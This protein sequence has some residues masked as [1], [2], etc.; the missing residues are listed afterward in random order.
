MIFSMTSLIAVLNFTS[1]PM[2]GWLAAAALPWLIHRWQQ[3]HFQVTS[4]AAV[5]LLQ[6]AMR[7]RGR[8][9]QMQQWLLLAVRTAVL[10]LTA[11]AASEPRLQ[12]WAEGP[13]GRVQTH[14]IL[15]LDQS[16]S[17]G[18]VQA[19]KTRWQSALH[20]ARLWIKSCDGDTFTLLASGEQTEN[21]LGR[22]TADTSIALAALED[23]QL[24][25]TSGNL[26]AVLH[27]IDVAIDRAEEEMPQVLTHHVVFCTDLGPSTWSADE[28]Q[29]ELLEGLAKRASLTI[30]NISDG[31]SNNLAVADVQVSPPITLIQ[32]EATITA[33]VSCFGDSPTEN[34]TVDLL[35]EG[36]RVAQ[37]QIAL[38][39]G[40]ETT[41]RFSHRFVDEGP[42]TV[43]VTLANHEDCLQSDD[44]RW[45]IV[46]VRPQ[47]Q[48][49]CFADQPRAAD[50]LVRA[51]VP[52]AGMGEQEEPIKVEV[53]P[54]S[55]LGEIDLSSYAAIMLGSVAKLSLRE[56]AALAEYV[57]Q[58]GGLAIFLGESNFGPLP[59]LL[60]VQV[61]NLQ[62]LGEYH[63]D[64]Q[65]Y[66]HVIVSPFRGQARSGLL[67]VAISQYRRLQLL[68][69]H[70]TAEVVLKFDT[71]D[72]ALVVDDFGLGRVSVSA[73]PGALAARTSNS[74]PWSSFAMSP[75][76]LPVIRELVAYL[77]GDRWFHQRNI[78]V[79]EPAAF[80]WNSNAKPASVRLP[81]GAQQTLPLSG[82]EDRGQRVFRETNQSGIYQ[83]A[84]NEKEL[85][86]FAVNLDG[87][88]SNLA[89][90]N[91]A[92]LPA[93]LTVNPVREGLA[94]SAMSDS[95][96]LA[97]TLL[98]CA[99]GLLLLEVSLA[100][101]LGRRWE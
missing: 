88:D 37:Q 89:P 73:L 8:R 59:E 44:E 5:E 81:D 11:L 55:R 82:A 31:R 25:Q 86:R 52:I 40:T 100:Y 39:A 13:G 60:P 64:P 78:S 6:K 65:E 79:G 61:G 35:V 33:T 95:F 19:G 51:L 75:S 23:L 34:T 77:V 83:F 96:P 72:P 71:G 92:T 54:A 28:R 62:P 1:F 98:A 69:E 46:N 63:F 18:C 84:S 56:S 85:A 10:I 101:M 3:R 30:V 97:R 32:R 49:A 53:F 7:H 91:E 99:L 21:L 4:W 45:L 94:L 48:V 9:V 66:G 93:E 24:S 20:H 57:R 47:L 68:R 36:R 76:F 15:V 50:D 12:Q 17:M 80:V 43:Q 29:R 27:A 14:R 74:T 41:L 38:Q 26:T 90:I 70:S 16:Y 42:H 67:G 22:P 58:G 87:R 2:L